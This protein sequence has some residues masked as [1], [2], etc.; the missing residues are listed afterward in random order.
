MHLPLPGR[1]RALS[2]ALTSLALCGPS[3]WAEG[4]E[5]VVQVE[6]AADPFSRADGTGY[7]N[8]V[9]LAAFKA[10]GVNARLEVVPYARCKANVLAGKVAAC[11]SMSW[12][13]SFAGRLVFS[14]QPLF[15]V[16]AML[17]ADAQRPLAASRADQLR[18]GTVVGIVNGFEYPASVDKL[19][20]QGLV[21]EPSSSDEINLR[22]LAAGRLDAAVLM[23]STR[24]DEPP[25]PRSLKGSKGYVRVLELGAMGSHIGFSLKHPAG[26]AARRQFDEGLRRIQADGT[27]KRIAKQWRS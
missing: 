18:P 17:V 6:D 2:L 25:D 20:S 12:D 4:S 21:L 16:H 9:V 7:A 27:L 15:S 11:F 1:R 3:A 13:P 24:P 26:E 14:D 5:L 10:A 22:K 8:D 19:A 23:V